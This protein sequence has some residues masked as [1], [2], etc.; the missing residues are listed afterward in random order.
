MSQA[1]GRKWIHTLSELKS[2]MKRPGA[3]KIKKQV[4]GMVDSCKQAKILAKE[5]ELAWNH[6]NALAK[7]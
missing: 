3:G 2:A 5:K 7:A 6:I 4:M 1:P